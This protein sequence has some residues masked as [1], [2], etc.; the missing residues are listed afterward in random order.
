MEWDGIKPTGEPSNGCSAATCR[1]YGNSKEEALDRFDKMAIKECVIAGT[2]RDP[3][4]DRGR[5]V[6][7]WLEKPSSAKYTTRR[8][9]QSHAPHLRHGTA[10]LDPDKVRHIRKTY[11]STAD[12]DRLA[13]KY[14][15]SV[16][17]I[18]GV[19]ERRAWCHVTT[20]DL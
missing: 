16:S 2:K 12:L 5:F 8:S 3:T 17:A 9:L 15:V 1:C 10:K 18:R 13:I 14:S 20:T 7:V 19:I 6:V 4:K 11:K